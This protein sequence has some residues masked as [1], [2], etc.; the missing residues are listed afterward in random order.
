MAAGDSETGWGEPRKEVLL[1]KAIV[2][3]IGPLMHSLFGDTT[4][5]IGR[6]YEDAPGQLSD[7][8]GQ[9]LRPFPSAIG[10]APKFVRQPEE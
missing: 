4:S 7:N 6:A 1:Q 10:E 2:Q 8:H 5:P 9:S 3:G